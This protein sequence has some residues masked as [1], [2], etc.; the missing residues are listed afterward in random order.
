VRAGAAPAV[1]RLGTHDT[2]GSGTTHSLATSSACEVPLHRPRYLPDSCAPP[3]GSPQSVSPATGQAQRQPSDQAR[4]AHR[5][6]S[7]DQQRE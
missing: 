2:G 5:R 3:V 4:Q 7:H 1:K 6:T